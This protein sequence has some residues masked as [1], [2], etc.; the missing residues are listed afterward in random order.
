[1]PL[2]SGE[3]QFDDAAFIIQLRKAP[4]M[5]RRNKKKKKIHFQFYF[6]R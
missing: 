6:M 1:M 5:Y 2:P 3:N 4:T